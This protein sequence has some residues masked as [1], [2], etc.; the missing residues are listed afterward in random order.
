MS[1]KRFIPAALVAA[2]VLVPTTAS[3]QQVGVKAGVNFA[4]LSNASDFIP[5]DG[6]RMGLVGGLFVTVPATERFAFQIEG[7]YTEK[8]LT[9]DFEE[10]GIAIDGNLR[11]QY[12]EVPV[13]GRANFATQGSSTNFYIV[14][15]AA[16][17]FKLDARLKVEALGEEETEDLSD[18][19]ESFDLGLVGGAGV[20]F[21][22]FGVEA[23]Y[24]HGLL[25]VSKD[26]DDDSPVKN[27]V[28]AVTVGYRFR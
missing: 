6:Q 15:G 21:G 2:A 8:G 11:L 12:L 7:L 1:V 17:A 5:D 4:S 13:L 3:A 18:D 14:A 22:R 26:D 20:E 23:R 27:K 28:F 9:A 19:M 16:P 24:T 25:S 10:D